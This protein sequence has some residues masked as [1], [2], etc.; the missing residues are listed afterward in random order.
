MPVSSNFWKI[1]GLSVDFDALTPSL[2]ATPSPKRNRPGTTK[3]SNV[4]NAQVSTL[5]PWS[6]QKTVNV[7]NTFHSASLLCCSN[8][9]THLAMFTWNP[10]RNLISS[11]IHCHEI[12]W[13]CFSVCDNPRRETAMCE[14]VGYGNDVLIQRQEITDKLWVNKFRILGRNCFVYFVWQTWFNR[15]STIVVYDHVS[16]VLYYASSEC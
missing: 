12:L 5:P 4:M 10:T 7:Y 15:R 3:P 11:A 14:H 13:Q 9:T 16:R 1:K 6:F 2:D 8:R